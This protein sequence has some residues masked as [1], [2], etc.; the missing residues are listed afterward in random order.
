MLFSSLL[1]FS[2]VAVAANPVVLEPKSF[3]LPLVVGISRTI[4]TPSDVGTIVLPDPSKLEFRRIQEKGPAIRKLLVIPKA[5]GATDLV[6]N[7][8]SSG[9]PALRYRAV[10]VAPSFSALA[11]Q[12]RLDKEAGLNVLDV[13]MTKGQSKQL[14]FE[15]PIGPI[16][17]TVPSLVM[18]RRVGT[19]GQELDL[20]LLATKPGL[21]DL[22][23]HDASGNVQSKLYID[24]K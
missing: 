8:P 16:Y 22:V 20:L 9:A 19:R 4:L 12:K 13:A 15:K 5:V 11:T 10:V 18:F 3:D 23:V 6:V 17:L 1:L 24:V 14:R 21:T 2:S 7:D